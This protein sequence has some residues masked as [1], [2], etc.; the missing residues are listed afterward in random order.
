MVFTIY[1]SCPYIDYNTCNNTFLFLTFGYLHTVKC[2][3]FFSCLV[4]ALVCLLFCLGYDSGYKRL[5]YYQLIVS[6][7][8]VKYSEMVNHKI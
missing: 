1:I 4:G 7:V 3:S 5:S 6:L 8:V 2:L